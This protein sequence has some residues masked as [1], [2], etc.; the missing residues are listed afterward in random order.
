MAADGGCQ[1]A[2]GAGAAGSAGLVLSPTSLTGAEKPSSFI[3]DRNATRA[4]RCR[5]SLITAARLHAEESKKGGFRGKWAMVTLT[6]RPGVDI[7]PKHVSQLVHCFRS[8]FGRLPGVAR[9]H[10]LRYV[11]CL[12]LHKSGR[13]H[14]HVLIRLPQG[15]TLPKPDKRGWWKHGSTNRDWARKPVGYMA[16]YASKFTPDSVDKLPKGYR[17]HGV[18]GLDPDGRRQ[19]R[20]WKAPEGA[21]EALGLFADIRKVAAGYLD[22]LTG[23][24]W[25]S[26]WRV[27]LRDGQLFAFKDPTLCAP[28]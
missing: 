8:Y 22:R 14:Y 6:Y 11:W 4:R 7:S 3:I 24:F 25:P 28:A 20:W 10:R 1:V 23:C 21:R 12:E 9:H 26:P 18:G 15:I 2:S 17:T 27:F 5:K 19:L 16:K 13:P